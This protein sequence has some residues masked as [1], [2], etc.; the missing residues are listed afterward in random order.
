MLIGR[1]ELGLSV[2]NAEENPQLKYDP[3]EAFSSIESGVPP[4]NFVIRRL[5]PVAW[6]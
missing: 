4:I 5:R 6:R 2:A 1:N 3:A